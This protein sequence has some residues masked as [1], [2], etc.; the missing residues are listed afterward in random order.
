MGYSL[1]CLPW[2]GDFCNIAEN[3]KQ[4]NIIFDIALRSDRAGSAYASSGCPGTCPCL[5]H[6]P[7]RDI[8]LIPKPL[9][10]WVG[11]LNVPSTLLAAL[12]ASFTPCDHTE[13]ARGR[14]QV[15]NV[16]YTAPAWFAHVEA[17]IRFE[18]VPVHFCIQTPRLVPS[19]RFLYT[20]SFDEFKMKLSTR[21]LTLCDVQPNGI[22]VLH[23]S[24][25]HSH[26]A[27][28]LAS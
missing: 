24:L 25:R 3:F 8:Q 27:R 17:T 20:I 26:R 11:Q 13:C 14:R 10:P 5:C 22:S 16:K 28:T 23:V 6:A 18:A 21:E 19:L 9:R 15:Q 2:G 7:S 12:S 4:H 1:C